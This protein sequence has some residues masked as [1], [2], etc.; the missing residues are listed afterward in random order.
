M[1]R[2]IR[3]PASYCFDL[4]VGILWNKFGDLI[5]AYGCNYTNPSEAFKV[6][7]ANTASECMKEC[8]DRGVDA[9]GFFVFDTTSEQC[10]LVTENVKRYDV[11]YTGDDN[12]ICGLPCELQATHTSL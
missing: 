11:E 6:S 4:K 3:Y 7:S 9:C 1:K 2:N 10:S 5:W 12:T 8:K